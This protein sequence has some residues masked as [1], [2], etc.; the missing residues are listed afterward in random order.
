[1]KRQNTMKTRQHTKRITKILSVALILALTLTTLVLPA[2]AVTNPFKD[3][4]SNQYY[5]EPVLWAVG[6]GITN[7][8]SATTF[9]PNQKCTRAQAVM[10]L[11][12]AA[13]K[14]EPA[15]NSNP[16]KDVPTNQY[17]Y[18][19]VL[20]AVGKGITS[21]TSKTEFSPNQGCTRGQIMTFVWRYAGM[22][23]GAG[24]AN[25]FKDVPTNQYYY[26]PVLW[27][28][29]KGITNGT[30]TTTF[31]PNQTCTRGQIMT[32]LYNYEVKVKNAAGGQQKPT[33]TP[34]PKPTPTPTPTPTPKPTST[35]SVTPTPPAQ[36]TYDA[37]VF[38]SQK[39]GI[40]TGV[41]TL[42]FIKTENPD[43][44]SIEITATINGRQTA[45]MSGLDIY[46]TGSPF[47]DVAY[48]PYHGIPSKTNIEKV[49]GGFVAHYNFASWNVGNLV[50]EIKENSADGSVVAK[51]FSVTVNDSEKGAQEWIQKALSSCT[52]SSM[53]P[54]E[55]MDAVVRYIENQNFKY[56]TNSG[57]NLISL[58]AQPNSPWFVAK[59]WD[60][61]MSPMVLEQIARQ[62]GGFE[63]VHNC[64]GDYA[65]G[66]DEWYQYH[67]QI[68]VVYGGNRY[69]YEVCPASE[70]G[71][72]GN[73]DMIDFSNTAYLTQLS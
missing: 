11:W 16:F 13:G 6:K 33:P 37:Y 38:D 1:M 62:I 24:T 30:S 15:S 68:Y 58:A 17:Y 25:P 34:T 73:F 48:T 21:G 46:G 26:Q 5:Y 42:F 41:D 44:Q 50:F 55:K 2:S 40:Y 66:T 14:P 49:T 72:V 39:A 23:S 53:N 59:R 67:Y 69:Y 4:P 7:G 71:E 36:Y 27:A 45:L 29:G 3:V 56:L 61:W 8:T 9:S 43:P 65:R 32:F 10:F 60:S 20:W 63:D 70:T 22:P 64:Y 12:N 31:S 51:R 52:T 18:K 47:S 28:V 57:E 35:P 54:K 19:A